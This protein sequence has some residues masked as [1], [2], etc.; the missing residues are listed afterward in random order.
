MTVTPTR[1]GRRRS[2]PPARALAVCAAVLSVAAACTSART[3]LGTSDS[4]CYLALPAATKAVDSHSRL[5]GAHLFTLSELR[6]A[7]PKLAARI[8]PMGSPKQ[9]LCVLAFTG[10]FRSESVSKPHGQSEGPVA[11]VVL[12][13]P[14][15]DVL[16]TVILKRVP[17]RFSH[18][19]IG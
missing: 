10:Q 8:A 18:S 14:S 7:A 5:L 15:N 9:S 17:L 12:T 4:S 1:T 13:R 3:N 2:S 11:I 19:H 16:G 6:H